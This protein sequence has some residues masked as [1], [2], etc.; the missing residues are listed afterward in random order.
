[1]CQRVSPLSIFLFEEVGDSS[2]EALKSNAF[3]TVLIF[4]IAV[5]PN[6]DLKYICCDRECRTIETIICENGVYAGGEELANKVRYYKAAPTAVNRVEIT[7]ASA[8]GTFHNIQKLISDF[9]S[10][11]NTNLYMNFKALMEAWDIDA[12]NDDDE[13]LFDMES[14]VDI[15]KMIGRLGLKFTLCPCNKAAFWKIVKDR[16]DAAVPGLVD[17]VYL[18]CYDIGIEND[19]GVWQKDL[20]MKVVPLLWV[21]NDCLPAQGKTPD[22]VHEILQK[23]DNEFGLAGGGLWNAY[24]IGK[25]KSSYTEY[26]DALKRVFQ[27]PI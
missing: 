7:L 10:G 16:L 26:G 1:M 13:A 9:G 8:C 19:P 22:Q 24:D 21:T 18:Q 14:T 6:G 23:W 11:A 3:N 5:L 2:T 25:M 17:R 20:G 12:V 27:N 15:A 4:R